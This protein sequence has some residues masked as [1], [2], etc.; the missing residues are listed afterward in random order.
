[1]YYDIKE[2]GLRIQQL[3]KESGLTQEQFASRLSVSYSLVTKIERGI[4]GASIDLL[5]ELSELFDV[6]LDY[7]VLGKESTTNILKKKLEQMAIELDQM[8]SLL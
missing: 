8:A 7:I 6:S 5:I 3:R 2:I 4:K 1:M